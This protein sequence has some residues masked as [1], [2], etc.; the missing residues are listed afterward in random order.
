M[1]EY[2]EVFDLVFVPVVVLEKMTGKVVYLNE[3]AENIFSLEAGSN[4]SELCHYQDILPASKILEI[5][6]GVIKSGTAS[7][8]WPININEYR[9]WYD[10]KIKAVE[11]NGES[12]VVATFV[13]ITEGKELKQQLDRIMGFRKLFDR[14]IHKSNVVPIEKVSGVIDE[15]LQLIGNNFS[16]Q[17]C[18]VYEY[19]D[20]FSFASLKN[21]WVASGIK[22][23]D[24]S[25]YK[26]LV[27]EWQWT[28]KYLLNN[29]IVFIS[30]IRDLP[31]EAGSEMNVVNDLDV[32][33]LLLI[34]FLH[35][36]K[37]IGVLGVTYQQ[38]KQ[39]DED[40]LSSIK[41]ISRSLANMIVRQKQDIHIQEQDK[42]YKTLFQTA[43]DA[44]IIAE[45]NVAIDCNNKALELYRCKREDIIGK[46]EEQF[47]PDVQPEG[48]VSDEEIDK[49]K[50]DNE[51]N[52]K[53]KMERLVKRADGTVFDADISISRIKVFDR[54]FTLGIIRDIS[55]KKKHVEEL[56]AQ[57]NFLR[58]RLERLIAPSQD[59]GDFSITDLFDV[60]QLQN[61]QD[62][63]VDA[64][65]VSSVFTDINGRPV[66]KL[67]EIN[68][69]CRLVNGTK[70][71]SEL[72][73]KTATVMNE[74]LKVSLK[75]QSQLCFSC[76]FIDSVAPIVVE[77][78]HIGNWLIGQVI[79]KSVKKADLLKF[80]DSIG[81]KNEEISNLFDTMPKFDS[82]YFEKILKLLTVLANEL[83]TIGFNN[84]KLARAVREHLELEKQLRQAKMQ[85]E[86]SDRLKSAFLAN[87]SHEIRTPMNGIVGFSDLLDYKNI[88]EEE[89]RE[90]VGLIKQSSNQLL[91]IINDI[92]DISKIEAGQ[93]NI[94]KT[95]FEV[96]EIFRDLHSF[97]R[98]QTDDKKIEFILDEND[99]SV[100]VAVI[101]DDVK[102]RQILTNLLSNAIKFTDKGY[103]RFGYSF[104]DDVLKFYVED[105]GMGISKEGHERIFD[106]F[107]QSRR[108]HPAKGGTGLGLAI[109]KAY[110]DLLGGKID[111]SSE[112]SKG[113]KFNV[114]IPVE[115]IS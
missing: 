2:S 104:D 21:E 35:R 54:I 37:L 66:T 89:R 4:I 57:K 73:H 52:Y 101:S 46:S 71:G 61:L 64:L 34:P 69:I 84:L 16:C 79:P 91:N 30:N 47:R 63:L 28:S 102:L 40:E 15:T 113:T 49:F 67:A 6:S 103:V 76:G 11:V 78:K 70:R 14:I 36:N 114:S 9:K 31:E 22:H 60:N 29:E 81:L 90:Y 19:S 77:G 38:A 111:V 72:C 7:V 24:K 68:D 62:A 82:E 51:F 43:S 48:Y 97:F 33:S 94:N 32:K 27:K 108:N 80:T 87:L 92:V 100:K 99:D 106:R 18:Y 98:K 12:L 42:I 85:A 93:V 88:E 56:K 25:F 96:A 26:I 10:V 3:Q 115:V 95:T 109:I 110:I 44:I 8:E 75:S 55:D 74:K 112:L 65:G 45:K 1:P 20:D 5:L 23:V 86:E 59:I 105:T 13:D 53:K 58:N 39:W 107:W 41:L 17:R 83:S 50:K